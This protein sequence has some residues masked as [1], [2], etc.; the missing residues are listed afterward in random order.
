MHDS[1]FSDNFVGWSSPP[2]VYVLNVISI[3]DSQ[4]EFLHNRFFFIINHSNWMPYEIGRTSSLVNNHRETS[5]WAVTLFYQCWIIIIWF[6][7][8]F[9]HSIR[10]IA[11][12]YN[13]YTFT[14]FLLFHHYTPVRTRYGLWAI[15]RCGVLYL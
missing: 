7:D 15:D 6:H 1:Q 4:M 5:K 12:P 11:H 3:C 2:T 14:F 8:Q 9:G 13:T 10:N